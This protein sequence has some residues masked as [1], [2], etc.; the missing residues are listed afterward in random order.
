MAFDALQLTASAHTGALLAL[1]TAVVAVAILRAKFVAALAVRLSGVA[2]GE[3]LASPLV[4]SGRDGFE[5]RR[6]HAGSVAA[7]MVDL[8]A[9]GDRADEQ[10]VGEAMGGNATSVEAEHSVALL[11]PVRG[12]FPTVGPLVDLGPEPFLGRGS[13]HGRGPAGQR[14]A[15]QPPPLVVRV[16]EF[17][18]GHGFLAVTYGAGRGQHGV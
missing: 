5:V 9:L 16:A 12:P 14:V 8:E 18:C 17:S 6:I 3:A 4:L 2:S 1:A 10:L 13:V 15:V 7:Q 11:V